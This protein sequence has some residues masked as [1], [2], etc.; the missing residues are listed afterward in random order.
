[1]KSFA[2]VCLVVL[3]V[4]FA[5]APFVALI[6]IFG[7]KAFFTGLGALLATFASWGGLAACIFVISEIAD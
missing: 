1:M 6:A 5:F 4:C 3:A 7:L 2:I